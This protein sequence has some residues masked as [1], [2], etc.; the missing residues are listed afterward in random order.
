MMHS[1]DRT[2]LVEAKLVQ[3]R[4]FLELEADVPFPAD[5]D[6]CYRRARSFSDPLVEYTK[7]RS[8]SVTSWDTTEDSQGNVASCSNSSCVESDDDNEVQQAQESHDVQ[9]QVRSNISGPHIE[10]MYYYVAVP[11]TPAWEQ[12]I[13]VSTSDVAANSRP[14]IAELQARVR[15]AELEA[16]AAELQL[17]AARL[18]AAAR[19]ISTPN[20]MPMESI[21]SQLPVQPDTW[22]SMS[23]KYDSPQFSVQ[24]ESWQKEWTKSPNA[25]P[26]HEELTTL[27]LRH[28]PNDYTRQMLLDLLDSQ[29][30]AGR[31][32]FV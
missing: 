29:G 7:P 1:E 24:Q 5:H 23:M 21:S 9:Q 8:N 32:N 25:T 17:A 6:D 11:G 3:R 18:K 20:S 22:A 13:G 16:Q 15:S 28:I 14:N 30:L 31:Y 27:M 4:T 12:F 2:C 19:Q 10:P 26:P